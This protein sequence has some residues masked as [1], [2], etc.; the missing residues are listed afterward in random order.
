MV[1]S[2]NNGSLSSISNGNININIISISN[3]NINGNIN[4]NDPGPEATVDNNH[5]SNSNSN[6][7]HNHNHNHQTKT[8]NR[9]NIIAR[10]HHYCTTMFSLDDALRNVNETR[11][12]AE[13][14]VEAEEAVAALESMLDDLDDDDDDDDPNDPGGS[15]AIIEPTAITTETATETA[16]TTSTAVPVTQPTQQTPSPARHHEHPASGV[17]FAASLAAD[18]DPEAIAATAATAAA[19]VPIATFPLPSPARVSQQKQKQLP[20]PNKPVLRG[21]LSYVDEEGFPV[22]GRGAPGRKRFLVL[23]GVWFWSR[24]IDDDEEEEE[25]E[26]D[27]DEQQQ[28]Q[29]QE[30]NKYPFVLK[31]DVTNID[32]DLF[33]AHLSSRH[34]S[35]NNNKNKPR[36]C[37]PPGR[38]IVFSGHFEVPTTKA[39]STSNTNANAK[40]AATTKKVREP[41]VKMEFRDLGSWYRIQGSGTNPLGAFSLNG[42][43]RSTSTSTCSTRSSCGD[44]NNDGYEVEL[45]KTYLG[46]VGDGGPSANIGHN[47]SN[48]NSNNIHG[49]RHSTLMTL[50]ASNSN[51]TS[52]PVAAGGGIKIEPVSPPK[53]MVQEQQQQQQQQPKQQQQNEP[54]Q[55]NLFP[56]E[57]SATQRQQRQQRQQQQQQTPPSKPR[58]PPRGEYLNNNNNN[59]NNNISDN[60]NIGRNRNDPEVNPQHRYVQLPSSSSSS[61]NYNSNPSSQVDRVNGR[62]M[63][64]AWTRSFDT[65]LLALLDLFD[66][67]VDA[68]WMLL[69]PSS[70]KQQQKLVSRKEQQRQRQRQHQNADVVVPTKKPKIRVDRDTIGRNGVVMRNASPFIPPLHQVL[71]VY[72]S[73]K[74]GSGDNSIG[75]NGIGVKHAC[76]SLSSLSLVFTKTT[77]NDT[78]NNNNNNNID[79]DNNGNNDNETV[80]L[81]MGILMQDLQR[82]DGIVLPSAGW[83]QTADDDVDAL[84]DHLIETCD[85]HP[86]TW[87]RAVREYGEGSRTDGIDRCLEH[88]RVLVAH[89]DWRNSPNVFSVVLTNLKHEALESESSNGLDGDGNESGGGDND[90]LTIAVGG[91][92]SPVGPRRRTSQQHGDNH[93]HNAIVYHE[94]R[95]HG[96]G[97]EDEDAQRSESLLQTLREKL[98]YL[99]LHLHDLDIC[100]GGKPIESVYWERRL[101]ELSRFE[102]QISQTELWSKISKRRY[103]ASHVKSVYDV[104]DPSKTVRFFCGFDPYRCQS[105]W[106]SGGS[107]MI[108]KEKASH[109]AP[110]MSAVPGGTATDAIVGNQQALKIYLYSRQSGRLIKVRNDPRSEIGLSGGSTDYCQGLTVIIDDHNGTLPL[111]PTK[112]DT[113]YGHSKH[114]QI[115][116]ANLKEWTAA[117]TH[118]YWNYH[119][120]RMGESKNA[121]RAAVSSTR[122]SLEEAYRWYQEQKQNQK[123]HGCAIVKDEGSSTTSSTTTSIV[124]LCRGTFIWY[125][126]VDFTVTSFRGVPAIRAGKKARETVVAKVVDREVVRLDEE[127]G[128]RILGHQRTA[129]P[130]TFSRKR[131]RHHPDPLNG[132]VDLIATE[133][134]GPAVASTADPSSS[135]A[136]AAAAAAAAESPRSKK[137]R[138][139]HNRNAPLPPVLKECT[140]VPP[141]ALKNIDPSKVTPDTVQKLYKHLQRCMYQNSI[142]R[143]E[144]NKMRNEVVVHQ[145]DTEKLRAAAAEER[146]R[147]QDIEVFRKEAVAEVS[148]LRAEV[149]ALRASPSSARH[150]L[151]SPAGGGSTDH[152]T[153]RLRRELH[154]Y[155]SRAEFYKQETESKKAQIQVLQQERLRFEERV[156]ELE[157]AQLNGGDTG[158]LLQF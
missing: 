27:Q 6:H 129:T 157:E 76:A 73:S 22:M 131:N 88:L 16:T 47:N 42:T 67:A 43:A 98:P 58:S 115:H 104:S 48:S 147:S 152:A 143:Q 54:N 81:S 150:H 130:P 124:P 59:N 9:N 91:V 154:V 5:N 102:L 123:E 34:G 128:A 1:N 83:V 86:T 106:G 92:G 99:Y 156:Q 60:N 4:G 101:A 36:F 29:Q 21:T 139:V 74:T 15:G 85:N 93:N 13:E 55:R 144:T 82:D 38:G 135:L 53:R 122:E 109:G 137:L 62:G 64:H 79:V 77:S 84:E 90:H 56:H 153:E 68:S 20:L 39:T 72:K 111:N 11:A 142:L 132:I 49:F 80:T 97:A 145:R 35:N 52:L 23:E 146:Q 70:P 103:Y 138:S 63:W 19:A 46:V 118:F 151:Q 89:R 61:S 40:T 125:E 100:V 25:N 32:P 37:P 94:V 7:N 3:G 24:P 112:Q 96:D 114:G 126:N 51:S 12:S 95:E 119:R 136:L 50:T 110:A 33:V 69:P 107:G 14:R 57:S 113:A 8:T 133:R 66:N 121:V 155:K 148:R 31:S 44:N 120:T 75:E 30:N 10:N 141:L 2:S 41:S 45:R 158:D 65:P 117:I 108:K 140:G 18:D 127:A 28:Q 116:A 105:E 134:Q 71:Q 78:S 149:D 87:G 17:A 26:N